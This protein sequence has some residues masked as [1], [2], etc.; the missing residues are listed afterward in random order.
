MDKTTKTVLIIIGS[1]LLVC[2]CGASVLFATGLWSFRN[3]VRWADTN[4]SENPQEVVRFGSEIAD[5][6]VPEGFGSPY[7]MHFGEI[8]S[9]GYG[10]Q[11]KNTHILLTQFPEGTHVN[12]EEMLKL[13][14][15][16]SMDPDHAWADAQTTLIEEKPV[17]IRGQETAL[18][19]SEG[20]SSDGTTYRS[21]IATFQG[22][23]GPS[24]LMIA[25][26]IEEW[27]IE[28]VET[29]IASMQ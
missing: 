17:M 29:F 6:D 22:K 2:I 7:G 26:P 16:Y 19:I 3:I 14:N 15:Q 27:D 8:T 5:F 4:T 9:V 25:G 11:S 18:S 21:A 1:V 23:G 28:M 24:L 10:S 13:I 20:T 12:V